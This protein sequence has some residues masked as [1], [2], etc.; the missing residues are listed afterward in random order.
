MRGRDGLE[1]LSAS[2]TMESET[3]DSFIGHIGAIDFDSVRINRLLL[4]RV[5]ATRGPR[6][7][8]D[9]HSPFLV[10]VH[11]RGGEM[12]LEQNRNSL[13]VR[14]GQALL[15]DYDA[16][17]EALMHESL[18]CVFTY[19][20]HD[21][22]AARHINSKRLGGTA[23]P[24]S[25]LVGALGTVLEDLF[26]PTE[27]SPV[28]RR[29][30]ES[31]VLDLS[32]AVLHDHVADALAPEEIEAG[33]LARVIDFIDRHFSDPSLSI[34]QVAASIHA[35]SRYVH[36][37]FE[38]EDESAYGRIRRRRIEYAVSLL[39]DTTNAGLSISEIAVYSGFSN[40]SQFSRTIRQATGFSPPRAA[41]RGV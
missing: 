3:P 17:F 15:V 21:L 9:E 24:A 7:L 1:F 16:T 38:G 37:L 32:L 6:F 10:L 30:I 33:N 27:R 2:C 29:H 11:V 22:L 41:S 8:G 35:S 19:L 26:D 40:A 39:T 13:Q 12:I 14:L 18:D 31:A 28:S 20:P 34:G 25:P 36:K 5:A 4:S 23:I